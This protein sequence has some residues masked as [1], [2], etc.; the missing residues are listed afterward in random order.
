MPVFLCYKFE[1]HNARKLVVEQTVV[2]TKL[3]LVALIFIHEYSLFDIRIVAVSKHRAVIKLS[4]Q[5]FES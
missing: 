3:V 5:Q 2:K 1:N 4:T